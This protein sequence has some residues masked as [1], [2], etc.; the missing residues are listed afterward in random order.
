VFYPGTTDAAGDA[1]IRVA[2]GDERTGVDMPLSIVTLARLAGSLVDADGRPVTSAMV[3]LVPKRGDQPSP[4]DVLIAS[5]A[6]AFPR[7]M[8]SASAFS[9]T[10]VAPGQYTLVARTGSGQRG[11]VAAE[12]GLPTLWSVSDITIDGTD[13]DDLALR[14]LPGPTVTGRYVL[15]RGS[16]SPTD[17]GVLSLSLVAINPLPGVP[18]TF[19]AAM[20]P[21]GTFRIPSVA[22]GRY[23]ARVDAS[24]ATAAAQWT[25]KSAVVSGRDIADRPLVAAPEAGELRGAVVTFTDRAAQISGRLVD[26]SGRAVTRYSILVVTQDRSL[27]LP[28]ARRIRSVRPATDGSFEIG[29]LPSGDY[30]IAAVENAEDA[31]LSDAGFLSEVLTSAFTL[32][33]A[34][35]EHK[36]QDFRVGGEPVP[37]R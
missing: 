12:A 16:A 29:G 9:F 21:D 34:D 31:D 36:R 14:L 10:A 2:S 6:L 18:S 35:G 30:A 37:P 3:A 20:Q 33:L 1:T 24:A 17:S 26:V 11:A 4:V 8:V 23:L 19:R 13:R 5:G 28:N 7:A 32:T 15:E 22:P 25:L 27:W